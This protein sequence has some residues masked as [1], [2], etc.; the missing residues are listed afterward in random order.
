MSS[1]GPKN[2]QGY[3]RNLT[4]A[5]MTG[6][7]YFMQLLRYTAGEWTR[8]VSNAWIRHVSEAFARSS[9]Q[10]R[11]CQPSVRER[12]EWLALCEYMKSTIDDTNCP[13]ELR[14]AIVRYLRWRA[15]SFK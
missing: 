3:I 6:E 14:N 13:E 8:Q 2:S 1:D 9:G 4:A 15:K 7:P 10:L 5:G 12:V 11:G